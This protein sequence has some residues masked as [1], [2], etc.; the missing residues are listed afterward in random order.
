MLFSF[1]STDSFVYY[2]LIVKRTAELQTEVLDFVSVSQI[3]QYLQIYKK[4]T[5]RF[6]LTFKF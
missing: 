6:L 1:I 5:L 4:H 2:E 3:V